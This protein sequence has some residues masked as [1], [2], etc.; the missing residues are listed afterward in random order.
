MCVLLTFPKWYEL[1]IIYCYARIID[2]IIRDDEHLWYVLLPDDIRW[3]LMT[4][5][6]DFIP[7]VC[8]W[9]RYS[10]TAQTMWYYSL[11]LII[12]FVT[13][14]TIMLQYLFPDW[15]VITWYSDN[16]CYTGDTTLLLLSD[17]VTV[18]VLPVLLMMLCCIGDIDD[19][20]MMGV[21]IVSD[22]MCVLA[23]LTI[24]II[25][26]IIQWCQPLLI[27][28]VP[29]YWYSKLL[30]DMICICLLTLLTHY[31]YYWWPRQVLMTSI[32]MTCW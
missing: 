13:T 10:H 23:L 18:L 17:A 16:Y 20:I 4:R 7:Y 2:D 12:P 11:L 6:D 22:P 3:L 14:P 29:R 15:R 30:C 9:W 28:D 24:I 25:N 27:D 31:W 1:L 21:M 32:P 8:W 26:L 5:D 19:D